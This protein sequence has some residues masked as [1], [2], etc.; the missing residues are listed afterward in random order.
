MVIY[1][2]KSATA[3][4]QYDYLT[5]ECWKF[6]NINILHILTSSDNHIKKY[7]N[8]NFSLNMSERWM[9]CQDKYPMICTRQLKFEIFLTF[10]ILVLT[11]FDKV[12]NI[13]KLFCISTILISP[14]SN[15]A[16]SERNLKVKPNVKIMA[17]NLSQI[18][19][20]KFYKFGQNRVAFLQ[21]RTV[22]KMSRVT[23]RVPT[24]KMPNYESV[25]CSSRKV[26]IT[27]IGQDGP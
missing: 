26:W 12:T 27:E 1:K 24:F 4:Y 15:N 13:C 11:K 17:L 19:A 16:A 7:D 8:L 14:K 10:E 3:F 9:V 23:S 6:P 18:I 21:L 5:F 25:F 2:Q 20:Y 22:D